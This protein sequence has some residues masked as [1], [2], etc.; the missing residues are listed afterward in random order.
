MKTNQSNSHLN[1]VVQQV[2]NNTTSWIGHRHGETKSRISGQTFVCPTEGELDSIEVFSSHITNTI[3]VDLTL[4]SFDAEMMTWGSVLKTS[5]V[6]FNGNNTGEWISF[7]LSGLHLQKGK[8]YG[9]RLKSE[10]GLVGLGEAA[11]SYDHILCIGGQEWIANSED[12]P[13]NYYSY[14][15]LAFKVE[16]RA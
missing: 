15:S 6:E 9:F 2:T 13:G 8:A 12:Q 7:P 4:H 10:G 16:L 3:T 5:I 1:A 11:G 14:L